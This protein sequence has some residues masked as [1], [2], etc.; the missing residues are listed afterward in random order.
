[1]LDPLDGGGFVQPLTPALSLKGRG[2]EEPIHEQ[3][4]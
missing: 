3:R 1:M 4:S 2:G